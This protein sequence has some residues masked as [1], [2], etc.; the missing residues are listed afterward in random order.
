M[1]KGDVQIEASLCLVF[2]IVS[3]IVIMVQLATP[4]PS[5]GLLLRNGSYVNSTNLTTSM[6]SIVTDGDHACAWELKVVN[7]TDGKVQKVALE[8][9]GRCKKKCGLCNTGPWW[10]ATCKYGR[11]W[12]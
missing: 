5:G 11:R 3:S 7:A 9:G 4:D 2:F 12:E 1:G 6:S 8:C 10:G